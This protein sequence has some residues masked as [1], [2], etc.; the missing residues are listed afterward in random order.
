[1]VEMQEREKI[2]LGKKEKTSPRG[3]HSLRVS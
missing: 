1:L 2:L 3:A